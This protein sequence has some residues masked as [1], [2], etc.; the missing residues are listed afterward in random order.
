M[1]TRDCLRAF[2]KERPDDLARIS[3]VVSTTATS[4]SRWKSDMLPK[5]INLL[6]LRF[7][8]KTAGYEPDELQELQTGVY[9]L[10]EALVFGKLDI[11]RVIEASGMPAG[12][13]DNVYKILCRGGKVGADR[14]RIFQTLADSVA[15]KVSA[16]KA[17]LEM[18]IG[19]IPKTNKQHV[20]VSCPVTTA[21]R[22]VVDAQHALAVFIANGATRADRE[23]LR[24]ALKKAGVPIHDLWSTVDMLLS[25]RGLA[26]KKQLKE[27]FTQ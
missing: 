23:Q 17:E 26:E 12:V 7:F 16:K 24:A 5:A 19:P 1:N 27:R 21:V 6:A 9:A 4:L 8:L 3:V 13:P 10:A 20:G 15:D 25:E 22:A 18:V 14:E 2:L 11:N